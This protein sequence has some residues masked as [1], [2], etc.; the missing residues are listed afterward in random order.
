M[1]DRSA[2]FPLPIPT[3]RRLVP[4]YGRT[5]LYYPEAKEPFGIRIEDTVFIDHN[6]KANIIAPYPYE[7]VLDVA[8]YSDKNAEEGHDK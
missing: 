3:V 2:D 8:P 6:G 4:F 1:K 5:G 7:F